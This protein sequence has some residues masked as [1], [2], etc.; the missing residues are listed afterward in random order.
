MA[1][2]IPQPDMQRTIQG[3][4]PEQ[5][6]SGIELSTCNPIHSRDWS[7]IH[8]FHSHRWANGNLA[9]WLTGC[10]YVELSL[11][12]ITG[13]SSL[14]SSF[15]SVPEDPLGP[16]SIGHVNQADSAIECAH[17]NMKRKVIK[18][19]M[20][21]IMINP[22]MMLRLQ[23]LKNPVLPDFWPIHFVFNQSVQLSVLMSVHLVVEG[24]RNAVDISDS[25]SAERILDDRVVVKEELQH[26]RIASVGRRAV[27][28][29]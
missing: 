24:L 14:Y 25:A 13:R 11:A 29:P 9:R 17:V 21:A 7:F 28:G 8:L 22:K 3:F 12:R 5:F 16:R 6:T 10:Q 15:I 19:Y 4:R 26:V 23:T 1:P 18:L 27:G 20:L 2:S